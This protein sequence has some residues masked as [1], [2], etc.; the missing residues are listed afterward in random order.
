MRQDS[1]EVS[2]TSRNRRAKVVEDIAAGPIGNTD[3]IALGC[4]P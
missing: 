1:V 3:P 2:A 4:G